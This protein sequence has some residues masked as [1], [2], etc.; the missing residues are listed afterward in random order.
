MHT[1][2]T[3]ALRHSFA[4]QARIVASNV[5]FLNELQENDKVLLNLSRVWPENCSPFEVLPIL[6]VSIT[7]LNKGEKVMENI[8]LMVEE[9]EEVVAPGVALAD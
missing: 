4:F 6:A 1:I 2:F 7:S 9:M 5:L 3:T 8:E